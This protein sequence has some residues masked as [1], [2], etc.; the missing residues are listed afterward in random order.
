L[1]YGL[2][3]E[4]SP[5]G[6]VIH[7]PPD[8]SI[9]GQL[10][11]P[12]FSNGRLAIVDFNIPSNGRFSQEDLRLLWDAGAEL[13]RWK[14]RMALARQT[15]TFGKPDIAGTAERLRD[16]RSVEACA[17][18]A[19][20]LLHGWPTRLD[21]RP[22]W[23]P[24]G[25]SGGTEDVLLTVQEASE[26]GYVIEQEDALAITQSARWVGDRQRLR[27]S[28]VAALAWTVIQMIRQTIPS[29][30]M[31]LVRSLVNP[32]ASVGQVASAPAGHRDPDPSSWAVPFITFAAACLR[33][34]ADLQSSIQGHGVVPLLDTDEL[35]EAWLAI[36]TR[37]ALNEHLG[38]PT[39]PRSG[40]L[41]AWEQDGIAFQLWLKPSISRIGRLFGT[42]TYL[43][44]V[45]DL[46]APDI[47]LSASRDDETALHILDAKSWSQMLPEQALEQS[48]KYLYG[49]R[50]ES[51]MT[52]VPAI[53]GVDLVTCAPLPTTFQ[54]EISLVSVI[55]A[56]PTRASDSLRARIVA[57]TGLLATEIEA[58]ERLA[59]AF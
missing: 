8:R 25:V 37:S 43:P 49:I 35:Y 33:A 52:R 28:S 26:R 41:A 29:A 30:E 3:L 54:P 19:A 27:S 45:T 55:N 53:T 58:R 57:I 14:S 51:Q 39:K 6:F 48:A 1:P 9:T 16:W 12:I 31:P 18:A 40:A 32:I 47:V 44:L 22:A 50:R 13:A 5:D 56:T 24:I 46:L 4:E 59:S 38:D 17:Q 20:V 2:T 11:L 23:L 10:T 36:E 42:T 34:I 21:R 15:G 7:E